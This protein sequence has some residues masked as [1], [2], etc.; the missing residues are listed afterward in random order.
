MYDQIQHVP[1]FAALFLSYSRINENLLVSRLAVFFL[2]LL[3]V[4]RGASFDLLGGPVNSLVLVNPR[5]FFFGTF[6]GLVEEDFGRNLNG[7][8]AHYEKIK[9]MTVYTC[10]MICSCN[11]RMA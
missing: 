11:L 7:H 5:H 2:L 4:S 6:Q 1:S 9:R 3:L 8:L 10:E